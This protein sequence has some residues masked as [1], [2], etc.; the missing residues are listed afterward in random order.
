MII[1]IEKLVPYIKLYE[2]EKGQNINDSSF[3]IERKYTI[4]RKTKNNI[5]F[6]NNDLFVTRH[7]DK[8]NKF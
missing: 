2:I 6:I 8:H 5:N 1:Q 3:E 4:R 7:D